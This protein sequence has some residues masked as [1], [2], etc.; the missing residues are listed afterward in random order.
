MRGWF[1]FKKM[2]NSCV[3]VSVTRKRGFSTALHKLTLSLDLY[4]ISNLSWS[5][6]VL[7]CCQCSWWHVV[8]VWFHAV[9]LHLSCLYLLVSVKI[10]LCVSKFVYMSCIW[11]QLFYS[12]VTQLLRQLFSALQFKFHC[13]TECLWQNIWQFCNST[14][15]L[16][17]FTWMVKR[18]NTRRN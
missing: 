3:L 5:C 17:T 4:C 1:C 10:P 11:V 18:V 14:W 8:H 13:S 2:V 6:H 12:S 16:I 9:S 7:L 15:L